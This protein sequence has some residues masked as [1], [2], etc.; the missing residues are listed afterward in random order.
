MSDFCH[1][2]NT[3]TNTNNILIVYFCHLASA[4]I[5][6]NGISKMDSHHLVNTLTNTNNK[7]DDFTKEEIWLHQT[8]CLLFVNR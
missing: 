7:V 5:N 3:P 4:L 6:I 8:N 1:L 2:A